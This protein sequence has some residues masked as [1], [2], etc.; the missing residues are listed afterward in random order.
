MAILHCLKDHDSRRQLGL[1]LCLLLALMLYFSGA[2]KQMDRRV[3]DRQFGLMQRENPRPAPD[4]V[5]VVGIDA[6]TFRALQEPFELWHPYLGRFLQAMASAKPAVLGLDIA[7]PERSY[8]FLIA[9]YDQPLLQGLRAVQEK[10]PLVLAQKLD[11]HGAFRSLHPSYLA[12]TGTEA[13]ASVTVCHDEDGV[14]RRFDP[15]LCTVNAQGSTMV[16][17]MA[18]HLG[19]TNPGTGL[20]DFAAAEP[21]G[22]VPFLQVLEW[23]AR[24]EDA[25]LASV[26][27]GKPVLLGVV[28]PSGER[29]L[30]PVPLAAWEPSSRLVPAVL[31]QA[32]MLRSILNDGLIRTLDPLLVLL[33][34]LLAAL[35][36]IGRMGWLK[37]LGLAVFPF[38]L[39]L[40]STWQLGQ[41]WYLPIGGILLSGLFAFVARMA[42][43]GV[44]QLRQRNWL[45][46]TFG[47]YVG[48]DVLHEIVAGNVHS[49]LEGERIRLCI[50]FATIHDFNEHAGQRPAREVV[51]LLNDYFSGMTIAVHQHKGVI[52]QFTGSGMLAFF[53]AP[54]ALE[55]PEKNA[56]ESAQEMLLRLRQLNAR[57]LEQGI[58]PVEIGIALHTDMVIIGHIGSDSRREYTIIGEAVS[59]TTRLAALGKDLRYP[60]LCSAAVAGAVENTGS[61][62]DCGEQVVAGGTLH[63]YGWNP[64][65]LA[66]G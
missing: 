34:T 26:F 15:N 50:L 14:V 7:L 35:F 55:C 13:L 8:Q 30:A 61:L 40:F 64:P 66:A 1:G 44:M 62:D 41:G 60:V 10:S 20:L 5:V 38:T 46:G 53:G 36:W 18:A 2:G 25:R 65:L 56:L 52:D 22:Y 31:M 43:D 4:D 33:L 29:V 6:A 37:L 63:V 27:G 39:I 16:E 49:G 45:R 48:H 17:K 51:T 24:G 58:E 54:Q 47:K 42:Y 23:Q 59:L 12:V 28:A 32:Q 57:W 19:R 11:D 9:Q 21:F 3:L